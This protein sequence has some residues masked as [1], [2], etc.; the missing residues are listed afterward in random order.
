MKNLK[1]EDKPGAGWEKVVLGTASLLSAAA[2]QEPAFSA[3]PTPLWL[4][5]LCGSGMV[6]DACGGQKKASDLIATEVTGG[7][8]PPDVGAG[9]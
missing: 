5:C 4:F 2:K 8:E 6:W 3:S 7:W 9:N 1:D